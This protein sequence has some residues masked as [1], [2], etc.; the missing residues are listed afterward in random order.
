MTLEQWIALCRRARSDGARSDG[1]VTGA[2]WIEAGIT[3]PPVT[4]P[5]LTR[6]PLEEAEKLIERAAGLDSDE[7]RELLE[8]ALAWLEHPHPQASP[9]LLRRMREQSRTLTQ[10]LGDR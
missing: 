6:V 4:A 10:A 5:P 3:P 2:S 9:E 7:A 1:A 8:G